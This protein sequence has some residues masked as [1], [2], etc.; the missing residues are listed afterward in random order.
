MRSPLVGSR[1]ANWP[2][3]IGGAG[4]RSWSHLP[5]PA[6]PAIVPPL[7]LIVSRSTSSGKLGIGPI[8]EAR[9]IYSEPTLPCAASAQLSWAPA[10][11]L[12]FRPVHIFH[13][14]LMARA[15]SETPAAADRSA[16]QVPAVRAGEGAG[17]AG[18]A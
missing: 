4:G 14:P 5:W 16:G 6:I 17:G 10:H 7:D 13:F 1:A 15:G 11:Y 18:Q 3:A 8:P 2:P 12:H 9:K